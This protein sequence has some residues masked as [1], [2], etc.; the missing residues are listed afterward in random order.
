MASFKSGKKT[1][2]KNVSKSK[3]VLGLLPGYVELLESLAVF[4]CTNR[5]ADKH[6]EEQR[7]NFNAIHSWAHHNRMRK[8]SFALFPIFCP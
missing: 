1:A 8:R 7:K 4:N 2:R 5:P 6:G 3:R